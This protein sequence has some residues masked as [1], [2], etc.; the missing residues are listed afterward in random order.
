MP[1]LNQHSLGLTKNETQTFLNA[2]QSTL[3]TP[4]FW[5]SLKL[6]YRST[7]RPEFEMHLLFLAIILPTF[8]V[9]LFAWLFIRRRFLK[10]Q[11]RGKVLTLSYLA[12]LDETEQ[13]AA[14]Q[15]MIEILPPA[16]KD[17]VQARIEKLK[18]RRIMKAVDHECTISFSR[19]DLSYWIDSCPLGN[20][21]DLELIEEGRWLQEKITWYK[22]PGELSVFRVPSMMEGFV[23][24]EERGLHYFPVNRNGQVYQ[25]WFKHIT[26]DEKQ[27]ALGTPLQAIKCKS[28]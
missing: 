3:Y 18:A 8:L 25:P 28:G 10:Y 24:H 4:G 6:L 17:H 13:P 11:G 19:D 23:V 5:E 22:I 12:H 26:T 27:I 2:T 16:L 20:H 9:C 7:R 15:N 14:I 1:P 21:Y